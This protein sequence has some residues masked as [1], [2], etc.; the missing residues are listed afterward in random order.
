[1]EE[2]QTEAT[3]QMEVDKDDI[4]SYVPEDKRLETEKPQSHVVSVTP[5]VD[6]VLLVVVPAYVHVRVGRVGSQVHGVRG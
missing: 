1:M 6:Q 2:D 3:E 4:T 5:S